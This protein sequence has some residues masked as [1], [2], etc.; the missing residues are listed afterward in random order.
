MLHLLCAAAIKWPR[1]Q[2]R[3]MINH[4]RLESCDS[5]Y[6]AIAIAVG[7]AIVRF[8]PAYYWPH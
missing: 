2:A 7:Y 1:W 6:A 4:G 8:W 3:M 5:V